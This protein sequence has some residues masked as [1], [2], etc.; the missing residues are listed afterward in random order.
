MTMHKD[1][2]VNEQQ[3]WYVHT[4]SMTQCNK[5]Q[6]TMVTMSNYNAKYITKQ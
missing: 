5:Q 3:Q 1:P 6:R 2:N 4:Q